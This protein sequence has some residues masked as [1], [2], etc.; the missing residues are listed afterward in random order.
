MYSVF[1]KFDII[2]PRSSNHMTKVGVKL[3]NGDIQKG[4][5][6]FFLNQWQKHDQ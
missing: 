4:D 3:Q 2:L 1:K 5:L 6:I